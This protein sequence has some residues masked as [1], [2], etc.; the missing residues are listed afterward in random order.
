M[1]PTCKIAT[2]VLFQAENRALMDMIEKI[3]LLFFDADKFSYDKANHVTDLMKSVARIW[4]M[5]L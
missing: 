3:T 1:S 2:A 4:D 5:A